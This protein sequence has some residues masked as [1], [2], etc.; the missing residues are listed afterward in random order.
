MS[1][2]RPYAE[3]DITSSAA[4]VKLRGEIAEMLQAKL[5]ISIAQPSS[6]YQ[7]PYNSRFDIPAY[8]HGFRMLVFVKF[9]GEDNRSTREHVSQFV[10]QLGEVAD[11]DVF[12]VRLF[13]LSLTGT[14]F[15]WYAALPPNS[16][17]SWAD[18]EQRFHEHFFMGDYELGLADLASVR[19]GRDE[20]VVEYLKRF[21][22]TRNRCFRLTICDSEL[23][24]LAFRGMRSFLKE[25]LEGVQFLSLAQLHQRASACE[26]RSKEV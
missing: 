13:S 10:A 2:H 3:A 18:M 23:A 5:G 12:R 26:S 21:R 9:S 7:K 16:I 22:D 19:Q 8:P 25:K 20:S 1:Y 15:A 4:Y 17:N 11:N 6:S 14:A 24:G